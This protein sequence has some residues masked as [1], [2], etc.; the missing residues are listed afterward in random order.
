MIYSSKLYF[1]DTL[2]A[3]IRT[4]F[5][6]HEI[7]RSHDP[8]DLENRDIRALLL[9]T[10]R[11][12]NFAANVEAAGKAY[13]N[14][15]IIQCFEDLDE[16]RRI[17]HAQCDA[18]CGKSV[19]FLPL[20]ARVEVSISLLHLILLGQT[21]IP[22]EFHMQDSASADREPMGKSR[23]AQ[24]PFDNLTQREVE[25]LGLAAKG[26]QNK[27]IAVHL[28]ISEHTVKLHMHNVIRKLDVRNRTEAA[29]RYLSEQ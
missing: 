13:P 23:P 22:R 3:V 29:H 12:A 16:T 24:A 18:L 26:L 9:G 8:R 17:Y 21:F 19:S 15:A 7:L 1:S 2:A 20:N 25:V 10:E 11:L 28:D 14:A 5:P 27:L 6:R 4:E